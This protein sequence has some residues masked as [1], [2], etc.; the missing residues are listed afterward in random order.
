MSPTRIILW[1]ALFAS[2]CGFNSRGSDSSQAELRCAQA[3]DCPG[4]TQCLNQL[5]RCQLQSECGSGF[6]CEHGACARHRGDDDDAGVAGR[7]GMSCQVDLT[8]G[9][10]FECEHGSC[11]LHE[12]NPN[13][14]HRPQ[15]GASGAAA[16]GTGG[17]TAPL[18]SCTFDADCPLGLECEHSSCQPHRGHG[19]D[20]GVDDHGGRDG[21]DADNSGPGNASDDDD[22][23]DHD[24]SGP[25][26]GGHVDAGIPGVSGQACQGDTD[27]AGGQRCEDGLCAKHGGP[28]PH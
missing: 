18:T 13:R 10:G 8:C 11:Q 24:N 17:S 4:S 7:A 16:A 19:D 21:D 20:A 9:P 12:N 23:A 26:N 15:A 6:E 25:G 14:P 2:A 3:S 22:D 1:G 5:C 27:C 28:G